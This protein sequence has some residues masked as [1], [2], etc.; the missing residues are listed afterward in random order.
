MTEGRG[1]ATV[2]WVGIWAALLI[3]IAALLMSTNNVNWETSGGGSVTCG[4]AISPKVY[5]DDVSSALVR[6]ACL[7]LVSAA[8]QRGFIFLI[9]ALAVGGIALTQRPRRLAEDGS[10]ATV[11]PHAADPKIAA[12]DADGPKTATETRPAGSEAIQ[13]LEQ[14]G[15]LRDAGVLTQEEFEAKKA[16][17]LARI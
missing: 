13:I 15:K 10:S 4:T 6:E 17:I 12:A 11:P 14:L 16:E 7:P 5:P 1:H 3:A 2:F 8:R 9:V